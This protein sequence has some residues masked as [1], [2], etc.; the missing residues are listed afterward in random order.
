MRVI[1]RSISK[2]LLIAITPESSNQIKDSKV[3]SKCADDPSEQ[4]KL[5]STSFSGAPEYRYL[6]EI[7]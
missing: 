6:E 3:K 5:S 7:Y 4:V 2:I 1:L